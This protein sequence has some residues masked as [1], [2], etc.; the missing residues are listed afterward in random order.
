MS[1]QDYGVESPPPITEPERDGHGSEVC[2]VCDCQLELVETAVIDVPISVVQLDAISDVCRR[3]GVTELRTRGETCPSC[4][5]LFPE[6]V[7][8]PDAAGW[9]DHIGVRV[10]RAD[11]SETRVPVRLEEFPDPLEEYIREVR[12]E[13]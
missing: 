6:T 2:P 9:Q 8:G 12:G 3:N 5:A 10:E 13:T 7:L 4:G 1:L 11:G